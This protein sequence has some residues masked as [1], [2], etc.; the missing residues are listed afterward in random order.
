MP[1]EISL[2]HNRTKPWVGENSSTGCDDRLK[3]QCEA[4]FQAST[5]G[6]SNSIVDDKS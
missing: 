2:L 1:L 4:G 6:D 5:T 3:V